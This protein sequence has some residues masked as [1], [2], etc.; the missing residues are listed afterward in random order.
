MTGQTADP[1]GLAEA[2]EVAIAAGWYT[3]D[4]ING[5]G[6]EEIV[7]A[8]VRAAAPILTRAALLE[9]ADE[10]RADVKTPLHEALHGLNVRITDL[11]VPGCHCNLV[12]EVLLDA[13]LPVLRERADRIGGG[14]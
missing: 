4:N 14:Q 3:L 9:A 2:I 12:A 7:P 10:I 6:L 1:P 11:P 5:S 13:L 8:A